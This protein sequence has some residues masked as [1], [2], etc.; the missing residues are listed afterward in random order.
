LAVVF[1]LEYLSLT[2][3]D[4]APERRAILWEWVSW[5]LALSAWLARSSAA[6]VGAAHG[7]ERLWFW[8]RDHW[9]VVWALRTQER[10]NRSAELARWPVRLTWFGVV[11]TG[12]SEA[13]PRLDDPAAAATTFRGLIR[14]FAEAWRIDQVTALD[15]TTSCDGRDAGPR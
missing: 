12:A 3:V 15:H 4:W 13:S 5:S 8:F 1:I 2:R 11:A 10:F 7:F 9:G 14:R 6:R